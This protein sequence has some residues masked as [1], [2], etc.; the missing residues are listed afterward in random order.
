MAFDPFTLSEISVVQPARVRLL[1]RCPSPVAYT[2]IPT[3]R[4][5]AKVLIYLFW[6]PQ[7]LSHSYQDY[8]LIIPL[9]SSKKRPEKKSFTW[10]FYY[11]ECASR[12]FI[13]WVFNNFGR[14]NSTYSKAKIELVC[15]DLF[16]PICNLTYCILHQMH[17]LVIKIT[18]IPG[19]FLSLLVYFTWWGEGFSTTPLVY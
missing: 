1:G 15:F 17:H 7:P 19:L 9:L 16:L 11:F 8:P 13:F 2:F 5:Q 18:E 14:Y 12:T 4:S 3:L 6:I 10:F